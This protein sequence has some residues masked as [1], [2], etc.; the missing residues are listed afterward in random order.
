MWGLSTGPCRHALVSPLPSPPPPRSRPGTHHT[1]S[2]VCGTYAGWCHAPS[3]PGESVITGGRPQF[4]WWRQRSWGSRLWCR[5]G[6]SMCVSEGRGSCRMSCSVVCRVVWRWSCHADCSSWEAAVVGT[7]RGRLL[8]PRAGL[9]VYLYGDNQRDQVRVLFVL[10]VWLVWGTGGQV[11]IGP[12]YMDRTII[13]LT[14]VLLGL[15]SRPAGGVWT[16]PPSISIYVDSCAPYIKTENGVPNS[17][18]ILR[19]YLGHFWIM[20]WSMIW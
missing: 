11:I 10:Y 4:H 12:R 1:A 7:D 18:K 9:F 6:L 13:K 5:F 2:N 17:S 20:T 3:R 19:N 16:P 14:R 15:L 8:A